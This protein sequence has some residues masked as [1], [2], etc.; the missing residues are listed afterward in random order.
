MFRGTDLNRV[1]LSVILLSCRL[2]TMRSLLPLGI[3]TAADI[4]GGLVQALNIISSLVNDFASQQQLPQVGTWTSEATSKL[5]QDGVA[6]FVGMQPNGMMLSNTSSCAAAAAASAS[7]SSAGSQTVVINAVLRTE[8]QQQ[9]QQQGGESWK[10]W[11]RKRPVTFAI[12]KLPTFL[13]VMDAGNFQPKDL[14]KGFDNRDPTV[15]HI[16]GQVGYIARLPVLWKDL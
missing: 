6:S 5:L 14:V 2:P 1:K 11:G 12:Y 13:A 15:L 4:A 9:Q 3:S 16:I 10:P 8:E 7:S